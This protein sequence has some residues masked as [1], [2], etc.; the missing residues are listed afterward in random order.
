MNWLSQLKIK[1]ANE[2][3]IQIED[4]DVFAK[5]INEFYLLEYD[6]NGILYEY[7]KSQSLPVQNLL[8]ES[9]LEELKAKIAEDTRTLNS[10]EVR[11]SVFKNS[12]STYGALEIMGSGYDQFV[13]IRKIIERKSK[14]QNISLIEAANEFYNQIKLEHLV[15]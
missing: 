6:A 13:L 1:L 7:C 2:Y 8:L 3:G 10:L 14:E 4:I 15:F 12:I 9:K 11:I 5:V